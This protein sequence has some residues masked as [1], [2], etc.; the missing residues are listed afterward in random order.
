MTAEILT[1]APKTKKAE[2]LIRQGLGKSVVVLEDGV[3]CWVVA[4]HNDP[5]GLT[6]YC[7]TILKEGDPLFRVKN[8]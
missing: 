1:L 6:A 3:D 7:R 8:Q 5:A 4:P 2:K